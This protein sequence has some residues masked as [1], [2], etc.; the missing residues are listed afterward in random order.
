VTTRRDLGADEHAEKATNDIAKV[1]RAHTVIVGDCHYTPLS[2]F[3]QDCQRVCP[4]V[5]GQSTNPT[6]CAVGQDRQQNRMTPR[7]IRELHPIRHLS[8]D[9][10]KNPPTNQHSGETPAPVAWSNS[11]PHGLQLGFAQSCASP[12]TDRRVRSNDD[13]TDRR[14]FHQMPK[15][16][17][18]SLLLVDCWPNRFFR[19]SSSF[20]NYVRYHLVAMSL[21]TTLGN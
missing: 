10:C 6:P 11:Q 7:A 20:L 2:I 19:R 13:V 1:S 14:W 12:H 8:L 3:E 21:P 18:D 9:P 17:P 15:V 5:R 16:S 4:V